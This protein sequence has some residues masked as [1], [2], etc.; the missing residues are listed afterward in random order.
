[1]KHLFARKASLSLHIAR[2]LL[3]SCVGLLPVQHHAWGQEDLGTL[4]DLLPPSASKPTSR[5][6]NG[7]VRLFDNFLIHPL[8]VWSSF[9]NGPAPAERSKI[10]TANKS[11]LYQMSMVPKDEV[12]DSWQ[13]L[14][15]I[16]SKQ[17]DK[18]SVVQHARL[19][20]QQ[21]RA[22]CSPS[23]LQVIRVHAS[24]QLHIQVVACGNYSRDRSKGQMAVIVTMRNQVGLAT[25]TRQ[26][27]TPAFQSKIQ[28]SWPV[29][30]NEMEGVIGELARSRL[31]PVKMTKG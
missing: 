20:M 4:Q 30:K 3:I 1:M 5:S 12:F 25:L 11:G 16:V 21:F 8:P 28:T 7:R 23:N 31:I 26:W 6:L 13:N 29:P 18:R 15:T 27:R 17:N 9:A 24:P 2:T 10:R 14:F 19:V 22:V